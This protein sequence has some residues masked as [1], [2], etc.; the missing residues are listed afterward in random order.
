MYQSTNTQH[1]VSMLPATINHRSEP[2]FAK[3]DAETFFLIEKMIS[4]MQ[5]V[6]W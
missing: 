6:P 3:N 5:S 4:L 2:T 1:T